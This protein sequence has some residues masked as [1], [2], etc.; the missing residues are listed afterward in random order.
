M[1][2][3][4]PPGEVAQLRLL[5]CVDP[6][7]A[8]R[9]RAADEEDPDTGRVVDFGNQVAGGR[10]EPG[11]APRSHPG[12][13]EGAV[14]N[15]PDHLFSG[16]PGPQRRALRGARR[17]KSPLFARKCDEI[18]Q[19]ARGASYPREA[20]FRQTAPR[21]S[22]DGLLDDAPQRPIGP[23]EAQFILAAEAVKN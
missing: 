3:G 13:H 12:E 14:R 5:R 20:S 17:A 16:E 1:V 23:L 9:G 11:M 15:V 8:R 21:E 22:L 10:G 4:G 19:T 7:S 2:E 18:P 6:K